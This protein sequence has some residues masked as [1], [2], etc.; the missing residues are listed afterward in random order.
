MKSRSLKTLTAGL[1]L[2]LLLVSC[3]IKVTLLNPVTVPFI[4]DH[5]RMV[6]DAEIQRNDSSWRKVR[7]WVDTGNPT[8][9]ISEALARDLGID[10]SA[11]EDTAFKSPGLLVTTPAALRFGNR[12][13]SLDSVK[14]RVIFQPFWLFSTMHIDANLP[15]TVLKK[16]NVVF[17]YPKQELTLAE[18]GEAKVT[19]LL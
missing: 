11:T 8:F 16:Y 1:S 9:F 2:I 10:L 18:P 7:L 15:A 12:R 5:N 13:I 6:V 4:T 3:Q 17:D 14:S 19:T